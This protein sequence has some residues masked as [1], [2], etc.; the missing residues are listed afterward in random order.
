MRRCDG[1]LSVGCFQRFF[2]VLIVGRSQGRCCPY[3]SVR[4]FC[5]FFRVTEDTDGFV[6]F[7]D[8]MNVFQ[9]SFCECITKSDS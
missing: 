3:R 1:G 4:W 9:I 5:E 8:P 6:N 7:S 2:D